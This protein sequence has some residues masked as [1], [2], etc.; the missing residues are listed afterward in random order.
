MSE[1]T[2]RMSRQTEARQICNL[3]RNQNIKLW[4]WF[5]PAANS[6]TSCIIITRGHPEVMAC[7]C[8]SV[9]AYLAQRLE[10]EQ[11]QEQESSAILI[12]ATR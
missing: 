10:Q 9:N 4:N 3:I 8:P 6:C 5:F 11:E 12:E 2:T 1:N 7:Y